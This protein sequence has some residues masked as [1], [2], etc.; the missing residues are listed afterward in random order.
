MGMVML[1]ENLQKSV[2]RE[3]LQIEDMKNVSFGRFGA[4][5]EVAL[6]YSSQRGW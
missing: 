1:R 4:L 5:P 3:Y 6:L 2:R